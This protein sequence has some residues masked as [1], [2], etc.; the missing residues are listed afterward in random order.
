MKITKIRESFKFI[1][2]ELNV[3]NPKFITPS[4]PEVDDTPGCPSKDEAML[5]NFCFNSRKKPRAEENSE[6]LPPTK[7]TRK[8]SARKSLDCHFDRNVNKNEDALLNIDD[9]ISPEQSTRVKVL[10]L[11]PSGKTDV[12]VPDTSI[13]RRTLPF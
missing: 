10:V 11:W 6:N 1:A 12:R 13:K 2:S 5:A 8:S 3:V 9:I 4:N 7:E